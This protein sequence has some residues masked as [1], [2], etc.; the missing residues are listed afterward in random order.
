VIGHWKYIL[1]LTHLQDKGVEALMIMNLMCAT[2]LPSDV[3]QFHV[4]FTTLKMSSQY[5]VTH[6]LRHFN[7]SKRQAEEAGLT[8]TEDFTVDFLFSIINKANKPECS[9]KINIYM[10]KN[11]NK[12]QIDFTSKESA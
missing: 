2:L 10:D 11:G 3:N 7:T 12:R 6:L 5:S 1:I 4:N 9:V 8:Y